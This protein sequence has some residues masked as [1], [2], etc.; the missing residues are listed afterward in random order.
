MAATPSFQD[1]LGQF[2]EE[3]FVGRT[4]QLQ[5]FDQWLAAAKPLFLILAV[6]GQG[7]VGKTTLLEQFQRKAELAGASYA[8]LNEKQLTPLAVR[9]RIAEQLYR[10]G[11]PCAGFAERYRKYRELKEQ[12]EADPKAP[13]GFL[14]FAVRGVTR[15]GIRSLRRVP[16]AGDV[17][18]VFL[19]PEAEEQIVEETS[20]FAERGV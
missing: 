13:K 7:G 6:S 14:D 15:V 9:A 5:M 19:A 11:K 20:A 16:V 4:E 10:Q 1:L 17:A 2:S 3:I 18:D 8:Y 12:V